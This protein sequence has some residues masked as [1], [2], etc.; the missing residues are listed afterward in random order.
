M[1]LQI[2]HIIILGPQGS[3]KGTQA[4]FLANR[5]KIPTISSGKLLRDEIIKETELGK[6]ISEMMKTGELMPNEIVNVLIK[7]RLA[8]SD[9]ENGFILDG[10]PRTKEQA[11]FLETFVEINCVLEITLS[12][13]EAIKRLSGRRTCSKCGKIYHLEFSPSKVSGICDI[14]GENL[15]VRSDD[16]EEAIRERLK[17]YRSETAGVISY[18][19]KKGVLIKINGEP[20]IEIVKDEIFKIFL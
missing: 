7:N 1:S 6:K 4:E 15:I 20:A 3:G 2:H 11:E 16:T 19:E 10:F 9:C 13:E 8:E 5:L 18:Y 14:D 17:I 12:D